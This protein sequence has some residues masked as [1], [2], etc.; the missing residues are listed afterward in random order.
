MTFIAV[1]SIKLSHN[2]KMA[3]KENGAIF[4][5]SSRTVSEI[6][7]L[8][9]DTRA[10]FVLNLGWSQF[11]P[12]ASGIPVWNRGEDIHGLLWP[13]MTRALLDDLMPPQP[14][15]FPADI[16][17]KTPGRGGR[18]KFHKLVGERL[19]LPRQWDWQLHLEGQE[20]RLITVGQKVVQQFLRFGDNDD[21]EYNWV[22]QEEVPGPL[23]ALARHAASRV[24]GHNVIAWDMIWTSDIRTESNNM[25]IF[26]GNTCPGMSFATATRIVTEIRK[27]I[28]EANNAE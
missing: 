28:E 2:S 9:H 19:V 16:W 12:G 5:R 6:M 10:E 22:P 11:N 15:E 27:Q 1:P 7:E 18:G 14:T 20:Y 26:E 24:Y 3:W 4:P 13:G 21:R 23:K 17:I 8:A 25:Y